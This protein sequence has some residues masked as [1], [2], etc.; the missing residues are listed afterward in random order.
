MPKIAEALALCC[1]VSLA[2]DEG[3]HKVIMQS[4]CLLLIKKVNATEKD[5]FITGHFVADI[6]CLVQNFVSIS[7]HH[8]SRSANG[9]AH[10]FARES[11]P[12]AYSTFHRCIPACIQEVVNSDICINV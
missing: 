1:A 9:V 10:L 12:V 6:K 5:H 11:K 2:L 8:V 7:F 3:L 4:D